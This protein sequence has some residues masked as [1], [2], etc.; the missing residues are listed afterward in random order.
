MLQFVKSGVYRRKKET[1]TREERKIMMKG[2][3]KE[4][5]NV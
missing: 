1:G 3:F 2:K 4:F 5:I